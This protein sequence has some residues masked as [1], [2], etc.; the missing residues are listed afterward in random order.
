MGTSEKPS[1]LVAVIETAPETVLEDYGRVMRLAG[2]RDTLS[3]ERDLIVKLNLSWTR[4]F[5]ACSSQPWQLE[6]TLKTLF[7]D[8]FKPE[9]VFPVENKTVVTDPWKGAR[10][11]KWLPVL[12][13][14]GLKFTSLPEAKWTKYRFRFPLL[15]VN[16]LFGPNVEVPEMFIGKDI[17][18]LPTMKTHGHTVTT[19]A[20]KN[21][22][23]GL[24][25][26]VRHYGH[27]HIHE[28]LVDLL[29]MQRELHP[30]VF[31]VMDGAVAGD[32]AGPR[33]MVPRVCNV[34]LASA[35][36]VALDAVAAKMMGFDPMQI[37]YLRMANDM[38]L[39]VAD[40]GRVKI[41]GMDISGIDYGF[42]SKRSLVIWGDQMIRRGPLQPLEGLL[43][44]SPLMI[45]APFAS[46]VYHDW[47]WYPLVGLPRIRA[48]RKTPWGR[49]FERY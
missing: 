49:L 26:E 27:K 15:V 33:T 42:V 30:S 44:H 45:W 2:Y 35:D 17:L 10:N 21:A 12:R 14:Y 39:G 31:A 1:A 9:R 11:N 38:G 23:G 37:G 36:P 20:V 6:G 24:L 4:Y 48:Y 22:F 28:V 43:L 34:L 7:E 13:Q 19:G 5:P 47:L 16:K 3:P 18:H 8:G 46:N 25:K 32:G 29:M 41:V 40:L